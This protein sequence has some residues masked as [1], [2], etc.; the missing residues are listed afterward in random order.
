MTSFDCEEVP[1]RQF[2]IE[3]IY[4]FQEYWCTFPFEDFNQSE[5][6]N[7]CWQLVLFRENCSGTRTESGSSLAITLVS[8]TITDS[9]MTSKIQRSSQVSM[10]RALADN[11][12]M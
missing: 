2:Q 5:I 1:E 8:V 6:W 7:L 4:F 11:F 9:N 12:L 3:K 10:K